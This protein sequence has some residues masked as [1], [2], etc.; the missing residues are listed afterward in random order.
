MDKPFF[1]A[2]HEL[3][4]THTHTLMTFVSMRSILL[5][6]EENYGTSLY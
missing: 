2:D 5:K 3:T 4:H 6:W 1:S